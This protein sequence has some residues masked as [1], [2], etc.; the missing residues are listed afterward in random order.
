MSQD[1]T[2]TELIGLR[3]RLPKPAER[4]AIRESLGLSRELVARELGV[5]QDTVYQWEHGIAEPRTAN[6]VNYVELLDRLRETA[7]EQQGSDK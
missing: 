1:M 3:A 2:I 5:S 4:R 7:A 6:L